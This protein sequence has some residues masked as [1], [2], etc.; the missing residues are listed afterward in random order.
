[1]ENLRFARWRM[2]EASSDQVK[3][4]LKGVGTGRETWIFVGLTSIVLTLPLI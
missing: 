2:A 1:M 4:W 3:A